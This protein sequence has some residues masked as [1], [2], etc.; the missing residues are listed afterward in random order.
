M[1]Q[2]HP[3]HTADA[4]KPF[5][6]SIPFLGDII[7]RK[8]RTI[9][10]EIG[11]PV[12]LAHKARNLRHALNRTSPTVCTLPGCPINN[13]LLCNV[14]FC[15]YK[16]LCAGCG[17]FYYGSSIRPLHVRAKEHLTSSTSSVFNHKT[18]CKNPFTFSILSRN[19]DIVK[20]RAIEAILIRRDAPELNSQ[21]E[22]RANSELLF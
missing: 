10:K 19:A 2:K 3:N 4:T 18:K 16:S 17:H 5:Y 12:R 7:D 14:K 6:L 8:I 9:F 22:K 15:V 20:L 1:L 11:L 13:P 21:I